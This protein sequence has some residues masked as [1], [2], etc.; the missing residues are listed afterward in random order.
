MS[1]A[2]SLSGS[3]RRIQGGGG[4]RADEVAKGKCGPERRVYW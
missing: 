3:G 4:Y 1:Q 2:C